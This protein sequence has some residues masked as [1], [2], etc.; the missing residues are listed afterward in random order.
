MNRESF[1]M[2]GMQY[3]WHL[4]YLDVYKRQPLVI[5]HD[6]LATVLQDDVLVLAPYQMLVCR[7][8]GGEKTFFIQRILS[9]RLTVKRVYIAAGA[10]HRRPVV[11]CDLTLV[12]VGLSLIHIYGSLRPS[13]HVSITA[14][15]SSKMEHCPIRTT[16]ISMRICCGTVSYTHLVERNKHIRNRRTAQDYR[17]IPPYAIGRMYD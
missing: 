6:G 17:R 1:S 8:I 2:T 3:Y 11:R 15:C 7:Y 5:A 4:N 14:V 9:L 16:T 12:V 13:A 10:G